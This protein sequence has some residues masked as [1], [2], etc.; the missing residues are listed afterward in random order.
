MFFR[1][2]ER[3]TMGVLFLGI[4]KSIKEEKNETREEEK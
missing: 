4:R 1:E 2:G 3:E